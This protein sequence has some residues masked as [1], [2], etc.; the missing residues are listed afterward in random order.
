MQVVDYMMIPS[1]N[2]YRLFLIPVTSHHYLA[3]NKIVRYC[4]I[5]KDTINKKEYELKDPEILYYK[6][7]TGYKHNRDRVFYVLPFKSKFIHELET[8]R[9]VK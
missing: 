4:I 1:T 6:I 3:G 8:K 2:C 9:G 7:F 5:D